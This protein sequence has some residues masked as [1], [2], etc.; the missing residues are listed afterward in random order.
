MSL[1][2]GI[3]FAV[4][5]IFL[6]FFAVP[7][8]MLIFGQPPVIEEAAYIKHSVQS[9]KL[10]QERKIPEWESE[11]QAILKDANNYSGK[12]PPNRRNYTLT[13]RA[14]MFFPVPDRGEA[15]PYLEVLDSIGGRYEDLSKFAEAEMFYR[16]KFNLE[17]GNSYEHP[18]P[19][20]LLKVLKKQGKDEE[21]NQLRVRMQKID[22]SY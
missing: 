20:K 4:V 5:S 1:E 8:S 19:S 6:V 13:E 2:K 14:T 9:D 11:A 7:L 16:K 21:A 22:P 10:W 3:L 15:E 12:I 18:N 17:V